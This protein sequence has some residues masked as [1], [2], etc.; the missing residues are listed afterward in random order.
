VALPA[1]EFE[2]RCGSGTYIRAIARDVGEALGVGAHL[3][4]L[5]RTASGAISVEQAVRLDRLGE[6]DYARA[7]LV[8]PAAALAHLPRQ[9]VDAPARAALL[10]GRRVAAAPGLPQGEP[11]VVCSEAHELVAVAEVRAGTLQPRKVFA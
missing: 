8:P 3:R 1:V 9:V 11:I 10:Q 4:A 5:R 6:T 2:V 7:A